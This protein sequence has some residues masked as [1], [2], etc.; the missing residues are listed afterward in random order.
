MPKTNIQRIMG[1]KAQNEKIC[2]ITC[3]DATFAKIVDKSG[4]DIVL[5]GD[6]LG[7]VIKG[8][9]GTLNVT[10][11]EVAYHTRAVARGIENAL[12]VS[13][14]PFL[15][16][17]RDD[18]QAIESAGKLIQSGANAVKLEGGQNI[19]GRIRTI[20][21]LGMPVMG[22]IGLMPQSVNS[23]GGYVIQGRTKASKDKL[24]EDAL[25]LQD[26]GVFALVLEGVQS[27]VAEEITSRLMIPTI[28]IGA[29][30][31]CDGQVLVLYDLLGLDPDFK[32]KFVKQFADGAADVQQACQNY[33]KEVKK[34]LFP[35]KDHTFLPPKPST[36]PN[37]LVTEMSAP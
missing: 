9:T 14:L 25:A 7:T 4:A 22:H 35:S 24:I 17:H 34:G 27:D 16:Y 13:D 33:I 29:G 15:T 8:E 10:L 2:M 5:I 36:M 6:S 37:G 1:K 21:E 20:I 32:P 3:Y 12:I 11:D 31:E 19:A 23:Q 18:A 26:A 30:S 28:G